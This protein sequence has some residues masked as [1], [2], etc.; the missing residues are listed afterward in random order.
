MN[1]DTEEI[2]EQLHKDVEYCYP[3][4]PSPDTFSNRYWYHSGRKTDMSAREIDFT[5]NYAERTLPECTK[6]I[7]RT[8]KQINKAYVNY[9]CNEFSDECDD[10][11]KGSYKRTE[12]ILAT[13]QNS[14]DRQYI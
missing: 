10:I 1:L 11:M 6:N 5:V 2:L 12:N 4:G 14:L 8:S 13:L 3:E 9:V 7:Y